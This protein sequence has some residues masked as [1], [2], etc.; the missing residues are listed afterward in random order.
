[1]PERV[2]RDLTPGMSDVPDATWAGAT[3]EGVSES[4]FK[5]AYRGDGITECEL[6]SVG[7]RELLARQVF[8]P[9]SDSARSRIE[10]LAPGLLSNYDR[11][12]E[13]RLRSVQS[14]FPTRD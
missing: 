1:M 8:A 4:L 7:L 9:L 12:F 13:V 2:Y 10:R 5:C 3:A 11:D 14:I 6:A